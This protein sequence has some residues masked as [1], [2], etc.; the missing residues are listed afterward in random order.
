MTL[1]LIKNGVTAIAWETVTDTCGRLPILIP[2]S[3][4]A[5]RLSVQAGASA[6]CLASGGKG[7]LLGGVPGTPPAEV[8]IIG[9]GIVGLQAA[10]MAMGLGASVTLSDT[11]LERLRA[12]DNG[13]EGRIRTLFS[14]PENIASRLP[15][16]DLI[17]GSV[18][19]PGKLAPKVITRDMLRL[20]EKGSALVDVA[21]DQGGCFETSK[22]TTHAEPTFLK[23]GIVHYCVANMP[24]ACAKTSTEA[25]MN[26]ITPYTLSL[27]SRGYQRAFAED[28]GLLNGLNVYKGSVTNRHVAFDLGYEYTPPESLINLKK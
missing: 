27:A 19:I 26:V 21:I 2:M 9:A 25:L 28:P 5:G 12:V 17:I 14:S 8:L 11:N 22:P 7:L 23:E 3:E 24:G 1:A 13:Y 10:R 6:L 18:L 16:S 20:L 4:V 15:K